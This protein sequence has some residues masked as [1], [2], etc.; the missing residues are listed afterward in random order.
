M[1]CS[2]VRRHAA[3]LPCLPPRPVVECGRRK[4][5]K[6]VMTDTYFPKSKFEA[7]AML[8]VQSQDLKGKTPTELLEMYNAAYAEIKKGNATQ[9][10]L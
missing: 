7:L 9:M 1:R 10:T 4:E 2:T 8:Y 6:T 3:G 5:V